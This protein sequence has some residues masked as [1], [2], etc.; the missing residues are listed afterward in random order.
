MNTPHEPGLGEQLRYLT[1]MIDA[2]SEAAYAAAGLDY[3]A[4]Y[5][6]VMRALARGGEMT[7]TEI[8]AAL[9]ITQGAVSQTVK[10][11]ER[12]GLLRRSACQDARS[13]AVSLTPKGLA[14]LERLQKHWRRLFAAVEELEAEIGLPLREA[15]LRATAALEQRGFAER[16]AQTPHFG[17]A[18]Q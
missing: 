15:L 9:T 14:L 18:E 12:D 1:E 11:M 13:S 8:T 2:G 16:L 4:R 3:R 7:V 10:L 6:P 5:T 17:D